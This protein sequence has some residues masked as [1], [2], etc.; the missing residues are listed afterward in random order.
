MSKAFE[1]YIQRLSDHTGVPYDDM[2]DMYEEMLEE[3]GI[4]LEEFAKHFEWTGKET[5]TPRFI[6]TG[7]KPWHE[8]TE[9]E[10]KN[11]KFVPARGNGKPQ[12]SYEQLMKQ[13]DDIRTKLNKDASD[14][15][16]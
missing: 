5:V 2:V 8:L 15:E 14:L 3:H 16:Q 12:T 7:P 13:L 11:I 1:G 10:K 9:E 4:T 6:G